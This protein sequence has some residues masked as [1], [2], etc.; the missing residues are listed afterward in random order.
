MHARDGGQHRT[1]SN[2]VVLGVV[3][4]HANKHTPSVSSSVFANV[5]LPSTPDNTVYQTLEVSWNYKLLLWACT[6]TVR[7][8]AT[9][10]SPILST[11]H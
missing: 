5:F 4:V 3:V 9:R 7:L 1:Q 11:R 2:T 10:V 6:T 8:H